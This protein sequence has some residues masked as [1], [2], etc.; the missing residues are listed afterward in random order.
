M[1]DHQRP[2]GSTATAIGWL[3]IAVGVIAALFTGAAESS[4]GWIL[5]LAMA[6]LGIGLGVLLLSLGYLVR[7]IWFLPGREGL[8]QPEP[9]RATTSPSSE[10]TCE[11]CERILPAGKTTC[12]A[13]S[14]T[15]LSKVADKV[16]DPTC[17]RQFEQRGIPREAPNG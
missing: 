16:T 8:S 12:T 14:P 9:S 2:D 11:W 6:N 17:L 10:T 1:E 4:G 13:L 3:L 15:Q 5:G 7:A